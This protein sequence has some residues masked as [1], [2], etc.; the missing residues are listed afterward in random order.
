MDGGESLA[1]K[2][3]LSTKYDRLEL[4]SA[5]IAE[6]EAKFEAQGIDK[7]VLERAYV[8]LGE[9]ATA[10]LER[11]VLRRQL[12]PP[13]SACGALMTGRSAYSPSAVR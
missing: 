12:A 7:V 2:L 5:R 8:R 6:A 13:S 1:A 9:L 11:Y 10:E 4:L 3:R